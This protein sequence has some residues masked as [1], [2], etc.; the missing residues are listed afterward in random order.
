MTDPHFLWLAALPQA[1]PASEARVHW[2][3]KDDPTPVLDL[4]LRQAP[5]FYLGSWTEQHESD[6]PQRARCPALRVSDWLFFK[7]TIDEYHVPALDDRLMAELV[8]VFEPRTDDLPAEAA[9]P[10]ELRAFLVDHLGEGVLC[11]EEPPTD[12]RLTGPSSD[13]PGSQAAVT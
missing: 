4:A 6:E 3:L 1:V 2:N 12:Q 7:G 11:Q 10:D 13:T 9:A 5:V 8:S